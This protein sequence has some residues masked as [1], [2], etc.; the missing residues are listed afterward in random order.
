MNVDRMTERVREALSDAFS[1]ALRERNPN[2]EPEHILAALLD[3][4][5]GVVPALIAK[6]GS[7]VAAL[8][9]KTEEALARL[10]RLSGSGDVQPQ[11][12]GG[13][14]R[15][16]VAA[17]DEAAKLTDEFVSVEHL[18][19]AMTDNA[20]TAGRLLCDAG[21]TRAACSGHYATCAAINA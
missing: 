5:Q 15:V 20:G 8:R 6:T 17:G 2:V 13:A 9:T 19:L 21:V 1:R 10:P 16:L 14:S 3:Q 12:S 11:L 4:R 7:D 18:L